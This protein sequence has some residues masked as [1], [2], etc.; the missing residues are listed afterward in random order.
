MLHLLQ[1]PSFSGQTERK[2]SARPVQV[3]LLDVNEVKK[4]NE[5]EGK[6]KHLLQSPQ[7]SNAAVASV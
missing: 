7:R 3:K 6:K 5:H 4:L 2:S 1:M